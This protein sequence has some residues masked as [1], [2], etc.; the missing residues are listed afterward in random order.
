M[1]C[2]HSTKIVVSQNRYDVLVK[3]VRPSAWVRSPS[4]TLTSAHPRQV[5][6]EAAKKV[7]ATFGFKLVRAPQKYFPAAKFKDCFYLVNEL[8]NPNHR[9]DVLNEAAP[10]LR[11]LLMV[12]ESFIC[13]LPS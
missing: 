5:L 3:G 11:G 10:E 2:P 4:T 7:K 1:H 6:A 12:S 9:A 8:G 13:A